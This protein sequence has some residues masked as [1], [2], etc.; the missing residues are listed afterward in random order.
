[1]ISRRS[2][3]L[4]G[5]SA[6]AIEAI[7]GKTRRLSPEAS[8]YPSPTQELKR[9]MQVVWYDDFTG[10]DG[11]SPSSSSWDNRLTDEWQPKNEMQRYTAEPKNISMTTLGM[12]RITALKDGDGTLP[13]TSGKIVSRESWVGGLFEVRAKLPRAAG[14]WGAAWLLGPDF[15][16]GWPACGEID[17]V[18][19]PNCA[20]ET[21][22]IHRGT[23]NPEANDP[24]VDVP[25]GLI[26]TPLA[27]D[28]WHTY[29]TLVRA[30][31]VRFFV[32]S[33]YTGK[34]TRSDV[35]LNGGRWVFDHLPLRIIL[36]LAVGGW[37][38]TPGSWTSES[39]YVDYVRVWQ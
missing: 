6:A 28:Q 24:T 26:R 9:Q 15:H 10:G 18:E 30:E 8:K 33:S 5:I 13:Y 20:Q 2:L 27:V 25:I 37:A 21:G 35:E 39:M 32:D 19:A 1:M 11:E 31:E 12:L 4:G 29:S 17:I 34:I 14:T 23:H 16:F 22:Y 38:S 7:P 36:N 3:I